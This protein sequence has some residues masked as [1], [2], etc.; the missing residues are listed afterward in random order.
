MDNKTFLA[1]YAQ[2]CDKNGV[3][4]LGTD[5]LIPID[6]RWNQASR[7]RQAAK[8]R[9]RYRKHFPSKYF[10]MTHYVYR[11]EVRVADCY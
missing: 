7:D 2:F 6:G 11:G 10:A 8:L 4:L 9:E 5:S 1:K 3:T